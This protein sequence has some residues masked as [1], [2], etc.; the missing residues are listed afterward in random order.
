M[1]KER[2]KMRRTLTWK[3]RRHRKISRILS[4]IFITLYP[5]TPKAVHP[6]NSNKTKRKIKKKRKP[7]RKTKEKNKG[8]T[9]GKT[10]RN[11]GERQNPNL[12]PTQ[13]C[14]F[15]HTRSS[16]KWC[17][18]KVTVKGRSSFL[19]SPRAA[20]GVIHPRATLA[21]PQPDS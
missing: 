2:E 18:P 9:K 17:I 3:G 6:L 8:K 20:L 11:W 12:N 14:N 15:W 21:V 5:V 4:F 1:E 13:M 10:K 19:S 7:K 16:T